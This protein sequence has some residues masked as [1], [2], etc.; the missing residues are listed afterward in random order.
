MRRSVFPVAAVLFIASGA[1]GDTLPLF[2][3]APLPQGLVPPTP[4]HSKQVVLADFWMPPVLRNGH[5]FFTTCTVID[6]DAEGRV[7]DVAVIHTSGN[8]DIDRAARQEVAALL[9]KPAV[10]DGKPV[11]VRMLFAENIKS[12]GMGTPDTPTRPC[13]WDMYQG[14]QPASH[15]DN[16]NAA[17]LGRRGKD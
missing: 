8:R 2:L 12:P 14:P 11:A 4:D 6:I 9:W 3:R 17:T 5:A 16:P 13:T 1:V 10:L 15:T 7:T